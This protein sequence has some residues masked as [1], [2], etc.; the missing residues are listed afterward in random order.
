MRKSKKSLKYILPDVLEKNKPFCECG[1]EAVN[2]AS[3]NTRSEKRFICSKG[4]C[5]FDEWYYFFENK[6]KR[7][8]SM[9]SEE[10]DKLREQRNARKRKAR[11]TG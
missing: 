2:I 4:L 8:H 9:S 7:Y 5:F 6:W 10:R 1:K 3:T 11:K